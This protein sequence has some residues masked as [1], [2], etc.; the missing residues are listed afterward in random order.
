MGDTFALKGF[1]ALWIRHVSW[2][3]N[4]RSYCM[5]LT[6]QIWSLTSLMPTFCPA[7]AWLRL[8]FCAP[9]QMRPQRVTVM[10]RSWKG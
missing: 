10:V 1:S 7:K 5:K 8:I 6:S 9:R 4:P 2:S 3:K